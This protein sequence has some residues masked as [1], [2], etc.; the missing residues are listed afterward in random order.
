MEK[1]MAYSIEVQFELPLAKVKNSNSWYQLVFLSP[2]SST[3]QEPHSHSPNS[4]SHF[5]FAV[6]HKI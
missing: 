6:F 1:R 4:N 5:S 3:F 2:V